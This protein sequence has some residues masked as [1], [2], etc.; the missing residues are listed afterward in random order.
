[1]ATYDIIDGKRV[2]PTVISEDRV[3]RNHVGTVRV[4]GGDFRLVGKLDGSLHLS[5]GIRATID[6]RQ[7]GSVHVASGAEVSVNGHI[8][9]SVHIEHGASVTVQPRGRVA[10]SLHNEGVLLVRGVFGGS[11]SG[12]GEVRLEGAGYIKPPKILADG[13][14]VYH[15]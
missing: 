6:G 3:M 2:P 11:R 8:E 7:H 4:E 5:P 13:S 1:M 12:Q 9:G 10:G 14:H 15:W